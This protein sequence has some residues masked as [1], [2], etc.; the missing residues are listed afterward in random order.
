MRG[1]GGGGAGGVRVEDGL[2]AG[3]KCS[4]RATAC[5][6]GNGSRPPFAFHFRIGVTTTLRK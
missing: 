3:A 4:L 6:E 5:L 1:G 2:R